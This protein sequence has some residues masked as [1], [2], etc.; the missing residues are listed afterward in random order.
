[1]LETGVRPE[2]PQERLLE[3][4]VGVVPS[5]E[6]PELR[7]HRAFLLLVEPLE[8]GHAHG[9]HHSYKRR[10]AVRIAGASQRCER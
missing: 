10:H 9:L 1:M 7:E 4:V 3:R 2:R 8:G 5:E 6:P